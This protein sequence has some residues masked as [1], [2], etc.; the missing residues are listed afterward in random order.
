[1]HGL[2]I[3]LIVDTAG[4]AAFGETAARAGYLRVQTGKQVRQFI[5]AQLGSIAPV[6]FIASRESCPV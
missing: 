5:I 6:Q 3:A 2:G 4:V 1:M